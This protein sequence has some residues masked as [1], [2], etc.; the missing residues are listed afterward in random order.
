MPLQFYGNERKT[1]Q[2]G[3]GSHVYELVEGWAKLPEHIKTGYTHGV[4]TDKND[5]VYVF[6]QSKDAMIV[7]DRDGN[8]L[9]SWG[10]EFSEG[11]HG[12]M[13]HEEDGEEFLYLT[14]YIVKVVVKTT[15]EGR[16]IFRIGI[17]PH[18]PT[19]HQP[20][21]Y[22]PTWTDI[23]PNGD[24]YITDGYGLH[25]VHHFD[26]HG[27][28]IRSW[29]GLGKEQ[30]KLKCPH[31]ISAIVNNGTLEIYVADRVNNRLQIFTP[32]GE[33]KR[34]VTHD[35]RS[36]NVVIEK[37][38]FRYIPELDCRIM[39]LD[40]KDQIIGQFGDYKEAKDMEGWPNIDPAKR[41]TG[42]FSSPHGLWVD[43]HDDIYIVE[44][45]EDGRITKL[46]RC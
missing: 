45:I 23:A 36:P 35:F 40:A 11:A 5:N 29:G 39:I 28:Y 16:E 21:E 14:D 38:G 42:K 19:Q 10:E 4:V 22:R 9:K 41:I 7:F 44:W 34:F 17:P 32:E 46:K 24:I 6:N 43:A 15:L 27:K 2:L 31:G 3:S 30:G 18:Q 26:K 12:L 33:F 25:F 13:I 20:D 37:D 1:M 8:F